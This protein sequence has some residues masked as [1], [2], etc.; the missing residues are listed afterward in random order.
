MIARISIRYN[1]LDPYGHV[2]NAAYLEFFEEIRLAYWRA[3]ADLI[4]FDELEAGDVPGARY[5]IAETTVRY[6]AP[7]FLD[8]ALHGAASIPT[9]GNRSYAM[10]FE[11][12]TGETFEEGLVVAEGFAAHAFFDP[13][14]DEVKPRPDWF[15]P[16]VAE[17]EGRPEESFIPV[18]ELVLERRGLG[19]SGVEVPVVGLGTWQVLDVRGSEEEGTPRGRPGRARRG[20]QPLRLL[21][22]VRRGGEGAR[23]RAAE[24]R[25]GQ[26]YRRH[27]GL[28]LE[29]QRGGA[30]DRAFFELFRRPR[31]ALPGPQPGRRRKTSEH[32]PPPERRG[33]GCAPS[34]ATHYSRAA[35]GDLMSVM[36]SG[37]VEF[38]QVPYNAAETT[39]AEELL[40]LAEELGLV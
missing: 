26:G 11:L 15:L 31:R 35:F 38:V 20:R 7:I 4:G 12:R 25:E 19:R 8:D 30:P 3:L 21:P 14:T 16:A 22:D 9:V 5:V 1:D 6:K 13:R 33:Q 18:T 24:V 36:R 37:R 40:P 34:G 27:E 32:A 39:A 2:N 23:R 28:D 10:D 29:R 17:L